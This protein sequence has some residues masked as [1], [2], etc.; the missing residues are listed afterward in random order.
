MIIS[1]E[2]ANT[3]L[4]AMGYEMPDKWPED[5]VVETL[6]LSPFHKKGRVYNENSDGFKLAARMMSRLAHG[7]K[8]EIGET[9][10]WTSPQ[11]DSYGDIA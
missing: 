10:V 5:E 4:D 11:E 3:I 7:D 2:D 8:I 1:R 6:K 9:S